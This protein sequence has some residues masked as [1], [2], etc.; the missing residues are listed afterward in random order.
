[1]VVGERTEG[2]RD[3]ELQAGVWGGGGEGEPGHPLLVISREMKLR[4]GVYWDF[5]Q[6]LGSQ[7]LTEHFQPVL[8][9]GAARCCAKPV[10]FVPGSSC[11][12]LGLVCAQEKGSFYVT[13]SAARLA[14]QAGLVDRKV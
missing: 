3:T 10:P 7:V 9:P 8:E 14:G 12:H 6:A 11:A 4:G 13:A 2:E 1:M 5:W